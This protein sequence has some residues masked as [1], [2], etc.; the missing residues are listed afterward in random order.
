MNYLFD[1][2]IV[3]NYFNN[4]LPAV[5]LIAKLTQEDSELAVS[6]LTITEVTSGWDKEKE[7]IYLPRL[8]RLF[9]VENTTQ[10]IS[11]SAGRWRYDF[12]KKGVTLEVVDMTIAATAYLNNYILVTGNIKDYPMK[13]V[14]LY[15]D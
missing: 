14:K 10:K 6:A 15:K 5:D 1:S 2:D 7:K 11:E 12:M 4:H 13:E 3:I 9:S 8:Y